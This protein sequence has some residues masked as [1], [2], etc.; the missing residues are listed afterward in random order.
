[1]QQQQDG[2]ITGMLYL[3][4]QKHHQQRKRRQF[5]GACLQFE[6]HV[7]SDVHAGLRFYQTVKPQ[8]HQACNLFT[9][10]VQLIF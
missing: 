4:Q 1:M 7:S 3:R 6:S 8:S 9:T 2:T 5:W 10:Y